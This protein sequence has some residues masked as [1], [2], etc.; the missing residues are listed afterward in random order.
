MPNIGRIWLGSF[1]LFFGRNEDGKTLTIDAL[2]KL[3]LGRNIRD[4]EHIDRV[5]ENP[6]GYVIIEDDKGKE[7]KLP[8]KGN[9]TKVAGLTPSEC[10]NIFVIRNSDLSIAHESEFYTNVTDRL[11]GLRTEKISK[12][13]E[14]LRD[15]SKITPSGIFRDIKDEK[16]KTRIENAKD[17]TGKIEGLAQE[18]TEE[19]FDE[20][21]EESVKLR[22]KIDGIM[23]KT[24]NLEDARRRETYEKGKRA[25]DELKGALEKLKDLQVYTE[26]GEQLWR[27]SERDV[28]TWNEERKA[29]LTDLRENEKKFKETSEKI[30]EKERDF[31]VFEER[32]KKL[33]D[34]V[35]PELTIYDRK[36]EELA[37]QEKMAKHL[38]PI[39]LTSAILFGISLLGSI[40]KPSLLFHVCAT[41][42]SI[43]TAIWMVFRVRFGI[44]KAQ[45]ERTLKRIK[46]T[47]SK[48]ELSAENIEEIHANIQKFTDKYRK[49]LEELEEVTR[50]KEFLERD[51]EKLRERILRIRERIRDTKGKMDGLRIE[52]GAASLRGYTKKLKLKQK[53]GK[54][55][56]QQTRILENLLGVKAKSFEENISYWNGEIKDLEE[57]KDKAKGM[58]YNEKTVSKLKGEE[59]SCN[60]K[61]EELEVKMS[62]F[63]KSLEEI[64]RE[65]NKIL[66]LEADYLHCKTSVDLEAVRDKLREFINEN[67]TSKGTALGVIRIFEEMEKE[68]KEKVSQLFGRDSSVSKYF[69]AI[70][71]GLYQEVAFSQEIGK[72]KVRRKDGVI[73]EAEKLSGGAYDQLY[74]SIRLALGEKLLKGKKGFFIMDDPFVKADPDRLERQ[75]EMLRKI[76]ELGWQV[77]YFSAKGEVKEA[78]EEDIEKGAINHVEIQSIFS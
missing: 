46:L 7:I 16:L 20:L 52:S 60:K 67:E 62:R 35:K 61:L 19:G 26:G 8:E 28:Q 65:A 6:E 57:Y 59:K 30:R 34:E 77:L 22:E 1:N 49:K 74:L 40:V 78:L 17:L 54:S 38:A 14:I 69:K 25:L 51:I 66:P 71:E 39:G 48:F 24:E 75:I 45:L 9:L 18:I 21:E 53:H 68:E 44:R 47:L 76:S 10:R 29:L 13:K 55:K 50:D 58:E 56:E 43:L 11:T 63:Q 31:G 72:I 2:V 33:D 70:T 41:F 32:K 64:E 3:L 12:I 15:L 73:L 23:Q 5:G 4:F 37:S 42:F 36:N 27:D